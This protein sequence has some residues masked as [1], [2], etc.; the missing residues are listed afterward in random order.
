M[1]KR[2]GAR[3]SASMM[4]GGT[5]WECRSIA[6]MRRSIEPDARRLHHLPPLRDLLSDVRAE[7][8]R[9]ATDHLRTDGFDLRL[10]VTQREA[11]RG[12]D[13]VGR[14]IR[15]SRRVAQAL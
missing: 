11:V 10:H 5:T 6:L 7:R 2:S 15:L 14:P 8:L 9:R 3:N 4:V 1:P 13:R 12:T